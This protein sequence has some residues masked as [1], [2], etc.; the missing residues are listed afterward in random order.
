MRM[1]MILY[2]LLMRIASH[3][4]RKAT[5]HPLRGIRHGGWGLKR[6]GMHTA[7]IRG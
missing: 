5:I 3:A 2:A 1:Q 6:Y 7:P 4:A